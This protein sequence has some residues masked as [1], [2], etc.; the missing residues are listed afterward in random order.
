MCV[1]KEGA[2]KPVV[3][4]LVADVSQ[5]HHRLSSRIPRL[6]NQVQSP[7]IYRWEGRIRLCTMTDQRKPPP[8]V[9]SALD[10]L[11]ALWQSYIKGHLDI[12]EDPKDA[13][14]SMHGLDAPMCTLL[15]KTIYV[16]GN[17]IDVPRD[18]DYIVGFRTSMISN[19]HIACSG[20]TLSNC[21]NCTPGECMLFVRNE[22]GFPLVN[23][24][25]ICPR[26][27]TSTDGYVDIIFA[28]LRQDVRRI[29]ANTISIVFH[30]TDADKFVFVD[31]H[32]HKASSEEFLVYCNRD[33]KLAKYIMH[34]RFSTYHDPVSFRTTVDGTSAFPDSL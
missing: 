26:I 21:T 30:K 7:S 10:E 11:S 19:V 4:W 13:L 15:K 27:R 3:G 9:F 31:A 18:G 34:G 17:P 8:V 22:T 12:T 24:S 23:T 14:A 2:L 20:I 33:D 25:Y 29:L 32:C 16:T 1:T 6:K 5:K 28:F